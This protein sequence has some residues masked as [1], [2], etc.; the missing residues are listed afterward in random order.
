MLSD[1][2]ARRGAWATRASHDYRAAQ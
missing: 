2:N 1:N